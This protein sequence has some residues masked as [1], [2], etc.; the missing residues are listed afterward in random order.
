VQWDEQLKGPAYTDPSSGPVQHYPRA[1]DTDD[2]SAKQFANSFY[3]SWGQRPTY[4]A[5]AV[6]AALYHLEGA[7]RKA[8]VGSGPHLKG[9][10][11]YFTTT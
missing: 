8:G 9:A 2:P 3:E 10:M 1:S 4:S 5:A 6:M 11:D 7:A